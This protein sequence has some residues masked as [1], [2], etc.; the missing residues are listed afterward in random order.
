MANPGATPEITDLLEA[1]LTDNRFQLPPDGF[2]I[3]REV[4][5]LDPFA[6]L[7]TEILHNIFRFLSGDTLVALRKASWA[8]FCTTRD[9][10]FWKWFLK[11]GMPW[12]TEMRLLLDKTRPGPEPS[13]RAL[14]LWLDKVTIPRYGM[15]GPFM[16]LA[17]RRRI[18]SVCEQ[19]APRYFRRLQVT[20]QQRPDH[21]ILQEAT[22]CHLAFVTGVEQPQSQ[23]WNVQRT[24]FAYSQDEMK[25][26]VFFFSVYWIEGYGLAGLSVMVD[27]QK[28]SFGLTDSMPHLTKTTTA[29]AMGD[30]ITAIILTIK[31]T[32]PNKPA[33]ASPQVVSMEVRK[34]PYL[35]HVESADIRHRADSLSLTPIDSH[36]TR[37]PMFVGTQPRRNPTTTLSQPNP[38][39]S[40]RRGMSRRNHGPYR[41]CTSPISKPQPSSPSIH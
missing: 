3:A 13:Y 21:S 23:S 38:P 24:L 19:L 18:W 33:N 31:T 15:E 16:G 26:K 39:P 2:K 12:L 35:Q 25:D 28:R 9:N 10:S 5:V 6:A 27:K 37:R 29:L 20:P 17:N 36:A 11:H 4:Q 14:Y 7:P 1:S 40:F 8:A 30:Y 41:S 22:C 32:D 34:R